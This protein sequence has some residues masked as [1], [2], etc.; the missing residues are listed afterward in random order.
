MSDLTI[1][2]PAAGASS[3]MRG[4]DKLLIAIDGVPLLRRT[5]LR[6]LA[7]MPNVVVTLREND[8]ARRCVLQNL[9]VDILAI[10]DAD[11]GLSS[12]LRAAAAAGIGRLM[13]LPADMPDLT[14]QDLGLMIQTSNVT[15]SD[16]LRATTASGVPGHPV[17]F[18]ADLRP[19]FAALQ[20]DEGGR[21]ILQA[22]QH[23]LKTV[24]LPAEHALTDLDTPEA[25][26]AWTQ[27]RTLSS[28]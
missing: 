22:H 12:S 17:I 3:R 8:R 4:Q 6:A 26:Q 21:T 27:S 20:G 2:I 1:V 28:P 23:R 13:V 10:R 5:A 7:S 14:S 19:S 18:P 24:A 11:L 15:P 16:I 9:P 25:W